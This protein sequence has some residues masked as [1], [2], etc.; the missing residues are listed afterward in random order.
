MASSGIPPEASF[1]AAPGRHWLIAF[2]GGLDS[3]VLLHW[4]VAWARDNPSIRLRAIHVHHGLHADADRWAQHCRR[5]AADLGV[6][7]EVRHVC[8]DRDG[9]LGL[10]AAARAARYAAI[11]NLMEPGETV[12]LA[13]HRDDQAETFLLNLARGAG[14]DGLSGMPGQRA[15]GP[16]W[17]HRPLLELSRAQLESAARALNLEWID[18]PSNG[19]LSLDRNYLRHRVLPL[20]RDR[21]PDFSD[22]TA[23]A[24]AHLADVA[25]ELRDGDQATLDALFMS[26]GLSVSGLRALDRALAARVLR[27]AIRQA[28]LPVPGRAVLRQIA[29]VIESTR[30]DAE[31]CVRWGVAEVRRYRDLLF[32]Q[33]GLPAIPEGWSMQ[34]NGRQPLVLP[35]G[36]G[37]LE[38]DSVGDGTVRLARHDDVIRLPE[39]PGKRLSKWCQERGIAPWART[40]LPVLLREGRM[41]TIASTRIDT[42][43]APG[44]LQWNHAIAG[45]P[46][47]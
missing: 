20:L 3:S 31:H 19:D 1:A 35:A 25:D 46:P 34:W 30:E 11:E 33:Q 15:F 22:R 26:G 21:W 45:V 29:G 42:R 10:E 41:C 6:S 9:G 24:A 36:V 39:R 5:Q 28:G 4:A 43:Y 44:K 23:S 18:D 27:L 7:L 12:L 37:S 8:V 47:V 14:L 13:H 40:R 16:G 32:I 2:S 17:I 38:S